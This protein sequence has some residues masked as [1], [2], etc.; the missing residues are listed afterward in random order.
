MSSLPVIERT[1]FST[2]RT[3]E[4]LDPRALQSQTGQPRARFGD[5][6]IKEL[7]DN[8]LDAAESARVRPEIGL[9]VSWAEGVA[10]VC[11]TD[12]GPGMP[13]EVV[14][15]ILDFTCNVSDKESLRSPTRGMQGNALKTLLGI[16][17]ALGVTTPVV[18]EAHGVRHEIAVCADPSGDVA[19]RHTK[20]P[21]GRTTGTSVTVP[22]PADLVTGEKAAGWLQKFALVNPHARLVDHAQAGG[23]EGAGIYE[24][25]AQPGWRKPLP[26]DPTS[27]HHYDEPA[28]TKLVFAHIREHRQGGADRT[29]RAFTNTFTGL[30]GSAKAK[31]VADQVPQ[32]THLSGFE[33]NPDQVPVLLAAMKQHSKLPTPSYLGQVSR[34]HYTHVL[35][36]A[37]GVEEAWFARKQLTD[38]AGVPW[39]IEVTLARTKRPG[40]V[41]FAVNYSVTFGDPLAH[42]HLVG[43]QVDSVG[44]GSFLAQADAAP[45]PGNQFRR[46]AIVHLVCPVPQFTDKGK[47]VLV[48]PREVADACAKALTEATRV[49]LKDKRSRQSA[50]RRELRAALRDHKAHTATQAAPKVSKKDAVFT[51]LREAIG[52]ARGAEGLSFSS[53]T[54]FYKIRPLALKLLP[55]AS[56]LKAPYVE[57]KLIPDWER[58]NG[59][60]QGLYR[61]PRGT[62]HHPH[63]P[64]G[65]RDV[66][67][68]TR[69]VQ[70]YVPPQWSYNKILVIEKTG[71]WPPVRESGIAEQYDMA[72][73]TNEGYGTEACRELLAKMPPGDVQIFVLHDAD[74]YGYNIA[75][76]LGEETAR[77]PDH[78]VKVID[79]GLSVDDAIAKG[80]DSE[81][82]TRDAALPARILPHLTDTAR[83]WFT[84]APIAWRPNGEPAKWRYQRVELNAF[85]SPE[86]IAY[87]K[88]GLA[89]HHAT[90]KVVPP[91]DQLR[92]TARQRLHRS[93]VG[94]V[95][96]AIDAMFPMDRLVRAVWA[97]LDSDQVTDIGPA[98]IGHLHTDHPTISWEDAVHA[99]VTQR[100]RHHPHLTD[101]ARQAVAEL[102]VTDGR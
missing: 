70:Q 43:D 34:D 35:D 3:A 66:R 58:E 39:S 92:A 74:P 68:G 84:G 25:T 94:A 18:I 53:H 90:G 4:F 78:R 30:T 73:I 12:N 77:M 98:D 49:L 5:V 2:S 10:R 14:E 21:T 29:V 45:G 48:V 47:T 83:E 17:H 69:E 1:V 15:R 97:G 23:R 44:V 37:F 96:E 51:V 38:K 65:I 57:Q 33:E 61:E 22:L 89:R 91:D 13:E 95:G 100:L 99:L 76:T 55:A 27:A 72:V 16:P 75:R 88:E 41:A 52:Q 82:D 62:L 11:V 50:D 67:L 20:A 28:M 24:P 26:T 54:L 36:Q 8:A 86:L 40:T 9:A 42:T 46:A 32:V 85:S 71:L 64:A 63:D 93:V 81:P 87:I 7:L 56:K 59:P 80:L 79:L 101:L 19:T 102:Q 60:I 6:V 31:H